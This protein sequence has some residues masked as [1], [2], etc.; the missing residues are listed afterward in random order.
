MAARSTRSTPVRL[1]EVSP[2]EVT[3][4][5]HFDQLDDREQRAFLQLYRG[6]VPSDVPL[7]AGE[8]VVFTGYFRV[9]Y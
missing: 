7:R 6:V 9:E 2:S 3:D 5:R 4:V 8:V 1:S